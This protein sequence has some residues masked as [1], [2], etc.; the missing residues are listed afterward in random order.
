MSMMMVMPSEEETPLSRVLPHISTAT[1]KSW[2]KL[3]HMKKIRLFI[4]RFTAD[5]EVDLEA[6]LSALGI[7]DVFLQDKAD[8]RHLSAEAVHIS[9]ALQKAKVIVNEDGTKAAAA[10]TAI[11]MARSSPPW[12]TVDRPFLFLIRHNPTGTI[13][14]MGQINKP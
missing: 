14:F 12:V 7:T 1:V 13:L 4:P 11:L 5:A 6:P 3:M 9:K 10:T 8:F 2:S